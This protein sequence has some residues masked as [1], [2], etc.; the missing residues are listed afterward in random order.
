MARTRAASGARMRIRPRPSES[1]TVHLRQKPNR[2]A[3]PLAS[4]E[5]APKQTTRPYITCQTSIISPVLNFNLTIYL[6]TT[7][8]PVSVLKI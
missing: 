3:V 7:R 6:Q 1:A 8:L 4:A 2:S 5:I